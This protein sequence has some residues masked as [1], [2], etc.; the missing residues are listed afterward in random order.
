MGLFTYVIVDKNLLLP[1]YQNFKEWQTYDVVEPC[2][3]TLE[4]TK[5]GELYFIVAIREWEEDKSEKFF[6]GYYKKIDETRIKLSFHG[7]M[8]FYGYN[9]NEKKCTE[10]YA[11]FTNGKLEWIKS[12]EEYNN[13]KNKENE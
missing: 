8:N 12:E 7:D 2:M 11:R 10:L 5:D 6:G 13:Y 4:I 9:P 3:E 1:E